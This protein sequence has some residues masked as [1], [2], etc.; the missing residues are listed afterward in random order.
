MSKQFWAVLAAIVLVF[1]GIVA[2]TGKNDNGNGTSNA[3]PT[4]HIEGKNSTGVKLVEYGDFQCPV[5]G[6]YYSTV[7][8]VVANYNDK[9]AFQFRNLPLTSLH[10]NAFASARA[11]EA[12]G[13]QGKYWEMHDMLYENQQSWSSASNPT[14]FFTTYAKSL[15]LNLTQFNKDYASSKTNS[16]INADIAAF[17]KTGDEKATPTFYLNGKKVTLTDIIDSNNE[18]SVEKFSKVI[19]NAIAAQSKKQ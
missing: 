3:K 2:F 6:L 9:I 11:A 10:P 7:K 5:C 13:D 14:S 16:A 12:A 18:P 4:N 1:V 15:N 17:D 8:Q 19:D